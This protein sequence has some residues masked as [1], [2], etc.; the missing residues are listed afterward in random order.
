MNAWQ[1]IKRYV[2]IKQDI[3]RLEW[4]K[5]EMI[6]ELNSDLRSGRLKLLDLALVDWIQATDIAHRTI[7]LTSLKDAGER[8]QGLL[9]E[10]NK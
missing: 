1:I 9:K 6:R 7:I 8:V 4:Q 2:K 10:K 3:Q 5:D